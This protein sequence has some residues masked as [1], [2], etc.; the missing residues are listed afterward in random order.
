MNKDLKHANFF[1][2]VAFTHVPICM[3]V[4]NQKFTCFRSLFL[5]FNVQY[6]LAILITNVKCT[7]VNKAKDYPCCNMY[8]GIHTNS[9]VRYKSSST[10]I[11]K[12]LHFKIFSASSTLS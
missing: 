10:V 2:N 6:R 12:I 4:K 3:Y 7:Y 9:A 11:I 5:V 8:V 1:V